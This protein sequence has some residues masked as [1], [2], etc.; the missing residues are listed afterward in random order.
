MHPRAKMYMHLF[1][2]AFTNVFITIVNAYMLKFS[3]HA[4]GLGIHLVELR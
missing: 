2:Q 4:C 1:M 3:T